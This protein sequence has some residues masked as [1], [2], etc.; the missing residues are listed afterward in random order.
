MIAAAVYDI[1]S[2]NSALVALL[3][4]VDKIQPVVVDQEKEYPFLV[5]RLIIEPEDVKNGTTSPIDKDTL[6]LSIYTKD[7][8]QG[9]E[10]SEAARLALDHVE[11]VYAT[12]NIRVIFNRAI[13]LFDED[14]QAYAV[15]HDYSIRHN[16]A[17]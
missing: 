2:N 15:D 5:Y 13:D 7:Y 1:L 3:G 14:A 8:M 4:N 12:E 16:K 17:G 11:G 10:I 9:Q 6:E